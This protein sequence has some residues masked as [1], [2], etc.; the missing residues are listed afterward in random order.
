MKTTNKKKTQKFQLPFSLWWPKKN[1]QIRPVLNTTK[2][3]ISGILVT[4]IGLSIVSGLIDIVFFSGLSKSFY[5]LFGI[6]SIPAGVILSVMSLF[7]TSAKFW[8]AMQLGA[9]N[10]LQARLRNAGLNWWSN[11]NKLKFK[12]HLVHKF[13]ISISRISSN[14]V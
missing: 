10:E 2:A 13:L 5:G 3:L 14:Y 11:L 12:W 8:C 4:C 9:I 1:E 7:F 6:W